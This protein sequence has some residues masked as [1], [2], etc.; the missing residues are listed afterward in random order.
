MTM[1]LRLFIFAG[2][3]TMLA[4]GVRA[5]SPAYNIIVKLKTGQSIDRLN[6]TYGTQTISQVPNNPIYLVQASNPGIV[7]TITADAA[8]DIAETDQPFRLTSA[9]PFESINLSVANGLIASFDVQ[10]MTTLNGAPVLQVYAQQ[11]AVQLIH[12][13]QAQTI[14]TGAGTRIAFIDTGVDPSHPAL[15][16]WLDPGIDVI[17]DGTGSEFD[18]LSQGMIDMLDQ[19]MIDVL[20]PDQVNSPVQTAPTYFGHGTMV[21]GLIHLAAP[22]ARLVP[23]KAFDAYGNTTN[24][25]VINAIYQAINA[26]VDVLN[27]SFTSVQSSQILRAAINAAK[28]S[29]IAMVAAVGNDG[30]DES[31]YPA[32]YPT[33]IGVAATDLNDHLTG[34]SNYGSAVTVTAPGAYLVS[35]FPGGRYAMVWGT[36][37]STPLVS[38][39]IALVTSVRS[40]GLSNSQMVVNFADPIDNL[41]PLF[42]KMLGTGRIDAFSAL[43]GSQ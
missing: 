9:T 36:S 21:A 38:G 24:F 12:L 35:T 1:R 29:G 4:S 18:G 2:I 42:Q 16:P 6:K 40:H 31:L 43:K 7:N 13:D 37:F 26:G 15:Q 23:I 39:T 17:A 30:A 14:S 19:G 27:M 41:N 34:F 11:P 32:A 20:D 25:A 33:V 10:T 8:V 22:N 5:G 3:F 28:G